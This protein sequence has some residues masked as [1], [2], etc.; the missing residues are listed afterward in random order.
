MNL[1]DNTY[2]PPIARNLY[3]PRQ[4]G[5]IFDY[6]YFSRRIIVT[7]NREILEYFPH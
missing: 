5:K 7:M 2:Y 1:N 3:V 6:Y 4:W